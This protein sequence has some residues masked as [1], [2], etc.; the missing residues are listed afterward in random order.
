M[1]DDKPRADTPPP[2][3][4]AQR[5]R[6]AIDTGQTGD[7]IPYPDPAAA[8]LGTDDEAAGVRPPESVAPDDRAAAPIPPGHRKTDKHDER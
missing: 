6:H 8:P 2:N 1:A 7:K 5:L 3:M 4:A